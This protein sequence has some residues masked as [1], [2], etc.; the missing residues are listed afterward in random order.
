[1]GAPEWIARIQSLLATATR[2]QMALQ[3][4]ALRMPGF[5]FDETMAGNLSFSD[6]DLPSGE[7]RMVLHL[8]ARAPSL[9]SYLQDGHTV[10]S[11]TAS[12]DGLVESA[13]LTGTLWILPHQ[14]IVR[15]DLH[16]SM[17]ARRLRL[18]GQ[19]DV[20]L[21][22]FRRTMSTLPATLEDEH[23]AQVGYATLLFDWAELPMFLRSF[24]K[25]SD[26]DHAA[27]AGAA[28]G[29]SQARASDLA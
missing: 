27:S 16:F 18:F 13:P 22:D 20:R 7:R 14:R 8:Q 26:T 29:N 10:L 12:I 23:G 28:D 5:Q 11:G 3:E 9:A 17:G 24:R 4:A 15:Y 2:A 25:T 6:G 1:M 21:L 19:K